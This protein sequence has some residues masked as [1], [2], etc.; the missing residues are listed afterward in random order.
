MNFATAATF[1]A[2]FEELDRRHSSTA[3]TLAQL[4]ETSRQHD[5]TWL[6]ELAPRLAQ[7]YNLKVVG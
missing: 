4:M 2:G 5:T 1:L 6:P 7:K 3:A